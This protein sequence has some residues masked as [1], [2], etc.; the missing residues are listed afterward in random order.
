MD[1]FLSWPPGLPRAAAVLK[2]V[3]PGVV[4]VRIAPE[5]VEILD[6]DRSPVG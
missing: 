3:A 2:V 4:Q 5:A 1:P 6:L